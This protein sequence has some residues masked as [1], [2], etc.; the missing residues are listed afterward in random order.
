MLT[1]GQKIGR[2]FILV[3][4]FSLIAGIIAYVLNNTASD[5]LSNG[6]EQ[7]ALS[8][9]LKIFGGIM[10]VMCAL[11]YLLKQVP[12]IRA[13]L[14]VAGPLLFIIGYFVVTAIAMISS[15]GPFNP[16]S[17]EYLLAFSLRMFILFLIPYADR[18]MTIRMAR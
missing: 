15:L 8:Q 7:L 2:F 4:V 9:N 6:Y 17:G 1:T 12:Q 13:S 10:V 11:F 14:F 3:I 18:W 5:K 16:L